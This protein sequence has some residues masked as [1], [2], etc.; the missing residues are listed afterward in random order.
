V[1]GDARQR[2]ATGILERLP[3]DEYRGGQ[4]VRQ[5]QSGHLRQGSA[6]RSRVESFTGSRVPGSM[7]F[8]VIREVNRGGL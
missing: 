3:R 6:Q 7:Y 2:L 5:R 8:R 1:S 4:E